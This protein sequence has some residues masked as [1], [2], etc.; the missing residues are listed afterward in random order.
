[1]AKG[2]CSVEGCDEPHKARGWCMRHYKFWWRSTR[3]P[4][5]RRVTEYGVAQQRFWSY[6]APPHWDDPYGCWEWTGAR[7]RGYGMATSHTGKTVGAH[8]YAYQSLIG[9]I[10]EGL[11][12]DHLCRNPGCVNP[13]HLEPV[14]SAE[15][16]RR[17]I[18]GW[19]SARI[20]QF[21]RPKPHLR[22]ARRIVGLTPTP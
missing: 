14:T 20:K 21:G 18:P 11:V 10:P 5:V 12:L 16:T 19:R 22:S 3:P 13:G 2:T 9:P 6:V 17:G 8:R 1:M 7:C 15:N 4:Q